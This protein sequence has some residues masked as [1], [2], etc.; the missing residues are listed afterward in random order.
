MNAA[1]LAAIAAA[2][3]LGT[4]AAA[5]LWP[6]S[7]PWRDEL[8]LL[9]PL[10][11]GLG[12]G[13]TSACFYAASLLSTSPAGLSAAFELLLATAALVRLAGRDAPPAADP[14]PPPSAPAARGLTAL[15]ATLLAQAGV[16]ALVATVRAY[17]AEPY[18]NSDGWTIWGMHA[19]FLF[20][21][22]PDWPALLQEP[23]L[24]WTH[25]DYP[26]LVPASVARAWAWA[27]SDAPAVAGLVSTLFGVAT[28][29][30]LVAALLR[31]RPAP[32][33]LA[34]GLLLVGTPFFV[35]FTSNQHADIPVG[36]FL[37]ATLALLAL[38][39][40]GPRDT[41]RWALAGLMAGRAAGTKNEGLLFLVTLAAVVLPWE[42]L[43]GSR[44]HAGALLAGAATALLPLL[45]FK[46]ALAPANDLVSS[47]PWDRWTQLFDGSRHAL[48][49]STLARDLPR[50]GEWILPPFLALLLPLLLPGVRRLHRGEVFAGLVPAFLL[51][52]FLGVYL[53]TPYELAS[54]L[55]S[56][57]VRLLLQLWPAALLFWGLAVPREPPVVAGAAVPAPSPAPSR[58]RTALAGLALTN[59]VAAAVTL[60]L[61]G[62]QPA[63]NE[64]GRG[65]VEGATIRVLLAEGWF[66]REQH[67][68]DTWAWSRGPATV[69]L[70]ADGAVGRPVTL[71]VTLRAL[72]PRLVTARVGDRVVWRGAVGE[73]HAEQA[74][75]GLVLSAAPL[76]VWFDTDAPGVPESAAPGARALTYA[77]YNPRVD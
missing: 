48:L 42:W 58:R 57:L 41:G 54:H 55:D 17:H 26:L 25:L 66:G 15:L 77:L 75:S 19:R 34:A 36:F 5:A 35:T 3:A 76:R 11:L 71:R 23:R 10:G 59:A 6:R 62:R 31:L 56:S 13:L 22:G 43:R 53:V 1:A 21:G 47:Q 9:L 28:A 72:G 30:L 14:S 61:L 8:A 69:L 27:G 40:R 50:F 37:L 46:F 16:V 65:R 4:L 52:G 18:S 44:R 60:A 63:A 73:A 74:I 64:L 51:A 39:A 49:L 70:H 2:W 12:L 24:G 32:I 67:G 45:H 29:G 68:A 33:A 38:P 7:R 20:R